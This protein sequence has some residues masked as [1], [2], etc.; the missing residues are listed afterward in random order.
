MHTDFNLMATGPNPMAF[1]FRNF[2]SNPVFRDLKI[3]P[4]NIFDEWL[5]FHICII[6]V[7]FLMSY[8]NYVVCCKYYI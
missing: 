5:A 2:D 6:Y 1:P 8:I 7:S 4:Q 3:G